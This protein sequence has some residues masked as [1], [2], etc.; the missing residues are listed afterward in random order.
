RHH[1]LRP[2]AQGDPARAAR[3]RLS[4]RRPRVRRAAPDLVDAGHHRARAQVGPSLIRLDRTRRS[5]LSIVVGAPLA[6][7]AAAILVAIALI[8]PTPTPVPPASAPRDRDD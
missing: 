4:P 1:R 6:L 8:P 3:R 2:H 5:R 7:V